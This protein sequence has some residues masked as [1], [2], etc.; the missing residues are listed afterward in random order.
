MGRL[1]RFVMVVTLLAGSLAAAGVR[2]DGDD[3]PA[4]LI[5]IGVL[6]VSLG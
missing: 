1:P 2:G 5:L 4:G 3:A 6:L